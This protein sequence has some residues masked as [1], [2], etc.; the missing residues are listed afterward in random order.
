MLD[1]CM[2]SGSTCIACINTSRHYIGYELDET[3][4][5]IAAKRIDEAKQ[6]RQ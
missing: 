5:D 1:N 4:F 2:G 3:Y 6:A